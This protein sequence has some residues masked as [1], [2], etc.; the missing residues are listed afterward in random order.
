MQIKLFGK[1]IF[2][3][4][5]QNEAKDEM[6]LH[7][8]TDSLERSKFMPDFYTM[9]ANDNSLSPDV[10]QSV[11]TISSFDGNLITSTGTEASAVKK[12]EGELKKKF[13][14]TPKKV[15]ELKFLNKK[16]FKIN[17]D[18]AYV[19]E[20]LGVFKDKLALIKSSE[21]DM[22]R[23]TNEIASLVHR[24]TNRKKYAAHKEFFDEYA[25]TTTDRMNKVIKN[26]PHLKLG[27]VEEFIADM[28]KEATDA[29]KA[30]NKHCEELGGKKSIF[31][32]IADKKDFKKTEQRRDPILLAQSPYAHV[33]QILGAWDEEMMFL[34]E[35]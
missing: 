13:E 16:D 2:E 12:K 27:K 32:I 25:Y 9:R 8:A 22:S 21:Y 35:L 6:Y 20:Q 15:F 28:P 34:E 11:A 4:S 3:F 24:L 5:K 23:G 10:W 29:M 18:E 31:Y 19:E 14:L 7:N 30:Y 33:W 1:N 26:H 17:T